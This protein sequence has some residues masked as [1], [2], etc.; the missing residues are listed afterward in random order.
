[1]TGCIVLAFLLLSMAARLTSWQAANVIDDPSSRW[2]TTFTTFVA[3]FENEHFHHLRVV[4]CFSAS[5]HVIRNITAGALCN[6]W[7]LQQHWYGLLY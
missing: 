1:M 6:G 4:R 2:P 5:V 7:Q 3:L